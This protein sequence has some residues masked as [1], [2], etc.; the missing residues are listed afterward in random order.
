MNDIYGG[1]NPRDIPNYS[2]GDAAHYLKI[3]AATIRSWTVGRNYP[4]AVKW[5]IKKLHE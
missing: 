3:P 4:V 1:K 2:I 5:I